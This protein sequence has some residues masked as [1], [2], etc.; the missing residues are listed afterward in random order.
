MALFANGNQENTVKESDSDYLSRRYT[1]ES[2]RNAGQRPGRGGMYSNRGNWRQPG[3]CF[4]D[5]DIN[6]ESMTLT[7]KI[8]L[9]NLNIPK[10][11]VGE[12]SYELI[13]PYRLDYDID[14]K[15]GD[16]ITI[17]GFEV[18]GY[19]RSTDSELTNLMVSSVTLNGTEYNLNM[20]NAGQMGYGRGNYMRHRPFGRR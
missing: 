2:S 13:I 4:T 17:S 10:L 14:I 12:N 18:P 11:T 16:E 20:M 6:V 3:T 7:G 19:R 8:D 5:Q 15:D 1:D 9:T